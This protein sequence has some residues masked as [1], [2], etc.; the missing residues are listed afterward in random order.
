MAEDDTVADQT[1]GNEAAVPSTE[2][3]NIGPDP[4]VAE[5]EETDTPTSSRVRN[6]ACTSDVWND[7]DKIYK[8]VDDV[9]VRCLDKCKVCKCVLSAKSFGGTGHLNRH[10][11]ACKLKHGRTAFAQSLL[12]F[13][14]DGS[15]RLWEY[16]AGVA[17]SEM[18]RLICRLDLPICLD[19]SSIFEEYIKKDHNP[20]FSVV[21]RQ[22]TTRDIKKYYNES[23][24]NLVDTFKNYVS[25]VT[26]TFDIWFGNAKKDYLSVVVHY[27]NTA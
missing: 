27:V 16:N 2:P 13:N 3:I 20:W 21:S 7:F 23:H 11:N 5:A 22:T 17:R 6:R 25:S 24:A 14:P 1:G 26:M 18:C 8:V 9:R 19:E 4:A 15:A 10:R 12:Q